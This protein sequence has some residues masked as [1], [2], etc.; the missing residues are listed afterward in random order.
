MG[1]S[2]GV[3]PMCLGE[4]VEEPISWLYKI[5]L[6]GETLSHQP[7]GGQLLC[8]GLQIRVSLLVPG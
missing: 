3:V 4:G 8:Y 2:G 1:G 6:I 7:K 5:I